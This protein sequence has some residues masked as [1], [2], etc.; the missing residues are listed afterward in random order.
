MIDEQL[1][2]RAEKFVEE[3]VHREDFL[4]FK[5]FIFYLCQSPSRNSVGE[6]NGQ[7]GEYHFTGDINGFT[8]YIW[9]NLRQEIKRAV[10]M[11]ELIEVAS[12]HSSDNTMRC[13]KIAL[14]Y[15]HRYIREHLQKRDKNVIKRL[16]KRF[17][18]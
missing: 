16:R 11:H 7:P 15:E 1:Y 17:S 12:A 8:I 14:E 10:L 9:E 18:I 13:H 5:D 3:N 2:R 6:I 4:D